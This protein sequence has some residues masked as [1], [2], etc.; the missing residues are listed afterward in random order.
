MKGVSLLALKESLKQKLS[1]H[2]LEIRT[3]HAQRGHAAAKLLDAPTKMN[4][5][6]PIQ[7]K[8]R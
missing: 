3:S 1:H 2:D 6:K 4:Y 7:S 8:V 5:R